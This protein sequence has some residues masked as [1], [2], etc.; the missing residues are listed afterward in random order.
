MIRIAPCLCCRLVLCLLFSSAAATAQ[1]IEP[2]TR[3]EALRQ[4]R[5]RKQQQLAPNRPNDLQ[6]AFDFIES[7][8]FFVVARDGF[9]PRFRTLTSGSGLTLGVGYRNRSLL[10]ERGVLDVSTAGSVREYWTVDARALFPLARGRVTADVSAYVREYPE[11]DFFG[12]GPDSRRSDA[13]SFLL[14]SSR[15]AG[16]VSARAAGPLTIGAGTGVLMPRTGSGRDSDVA[17]IEELFEASS[18]PAFGESL[19]FFE[20][21]GFVEVDLR[22]PLNP[23]R[24]GFYRA[25][26]TRYA[27]RS[28]RWSFTRTQL[29]L[30]QY[31][32]FLNGRRVIALRGLATSTEADDGSAGVPFYLMPALGGSRTLRGFRSNRFRG[33]HALLLQAEYRWEVW[34]GLDAALFYDAGKVAMQRRELNLKNLENDYGF[35]F[36]FNTNNGVLLRID[37][38]F[39]SRDGKHLHLTLS[40]AF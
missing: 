4:E 38:A 25:D 21:S 20:G 35:G 29:D 12:L 31:I 2:A 16:Q 26:V 14:R 9:Y 39:G 24:G 34:S 40:G 7:R 17:S 19:D 11:E 36:R 23:R 22:R 18:T 1:P 15:V 37:T 5:E 30:R 3:S 32:G 27:D 13:T 6:R 10:A 33:P 28:D 8:G